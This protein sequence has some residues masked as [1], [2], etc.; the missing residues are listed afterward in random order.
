LNSNAISSVIF[1]GGPVTWRYLVWVFGYWNTAA[2]ASLV[3]LL[4]LV[5]FCVTGDQDAKER[6][7][8]RFYAF[9]HAQALFFLLML[10]AEG[11]WQRIY[12]DRPDI[13]GWA[14]LSWYPY[15]LGSA[16][17]LGVGA[18]I[19][20]GAVGFVWRYTER[21]PRPRLFAG[22]A[23][24]APGACWLAIWFASQM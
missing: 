15:A 22:I 19:E 23:L 12:Q 21:A 2:F 5:P 4:F 20:L 13:P 11:L 3:P 17:Y 9:A 10:V 16:I 8:G 7:A 6:K 18:V 24:L 14:L 1:D